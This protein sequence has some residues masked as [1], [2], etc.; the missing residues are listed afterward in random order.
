LFQTTNAEDYIVNASNE[1]WTHVNIDESQTCLGV[2]ILIGIHV[3][4][5]AQ[6]Y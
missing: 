4:P 3:I 6:N 2:A 1:T 5:G